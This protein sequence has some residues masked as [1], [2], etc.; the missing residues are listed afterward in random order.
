MKTGTTSCPTLRLT[1]LCATCV[2]K[3]KRFH[4]QSIRAGKD[5][6]LADMEAQNHVAWQTSLSFVTFFFQN[7]TMLRFTR[8]C[9]VVVVVVVVLL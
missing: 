8:V 1:Q 2:P 9:I 5:R 4:D 7:K 6:T 3:R